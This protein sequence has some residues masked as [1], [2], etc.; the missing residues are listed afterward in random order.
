[1]IPRLIKKA[2]HGGSEF[3]SSKYEDIYKR[4][5]YDR[6]IFL[7]EEITKDTGSAIS[8]LLLYYDSESQEEDI[9]IYINSPGGDVTALANMYDVMQMV[10][11][12]IHTIC[13]GKAY[14]A[15]AVLLAS[16]TRGRRFATRNSEIMI[17]GVQGTFPS[18]ECSDT[19]DTEIEMNIFEEYNKMVMG[20][21]AK[22][23]KKTLR[24]VAA[25]CE[26]DLFLDANQALEYG[27]IDHIL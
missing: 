18:T 4:L 23:T 24:R 25:D 26:R 7:T 9:K 8:A 11:A 2:G 22:H 13:V 19:V 16:G 12:P 20:I 17:H 15:G 1:M 21:L 3:D 10:H 27:I 6:I 14:S 5:A